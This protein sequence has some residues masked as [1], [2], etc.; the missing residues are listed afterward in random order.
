MRRRCAQ[1]GTNGRL[2]LTLSDWADVEISVGRGAT[3]LSLSREAAL[4]MR[5][6]GI[7]AGDV[8]RA[9][10]RVV[11]Q[12]GG[13]AVT[14]ITGYEGVDA[15][16]V[17]NRTLS[18]KVRLI[19]IMHKRSFAE[20]RGPGWQSLGT[21]VSKTSFNIRSKGKRNLGRALVL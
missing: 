3:A 19:R 17:Q 13:Q 7:S 6:E 4:E 2:L 21:S 16:F 8:E 12:A 18:R 5:A 9:L 14:V 15:R 11:V 10:R 20:G 1:R